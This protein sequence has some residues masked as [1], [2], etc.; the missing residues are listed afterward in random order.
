[1]A[2]RS[3]AQP[4]AE[5]IDE[6]LRVYGLNRKMDEVLVREAWEELMGPAIIKQT[7]Y[8]KLEK[9][10]LSLGMNSAVLKEE[11]SYSKTK[12]KDLLNKHIGREIVHSVE[13]R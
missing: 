12:I 11:F 6:L 7:K 5:V 3:N 1:M 13:V 4:L 2:R 10:H 9:N 8:V